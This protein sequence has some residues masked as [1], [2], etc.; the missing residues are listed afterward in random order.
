MTPPDQTL[1][2]AFVITG[3]EAHD[4]T[5]Y[6]ELMDLDETRPKALLADKGYDSDVIREEAWFH[7]TD[8]VIPTKS[9]R[10]ISDRSIRCFMPCAIASSV[11]S[12]TPGR[13]TLRQ[14]GR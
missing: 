7:G 14:N 11:S 1:P 8:P 2:L 6:G 5:I 4:A 3:G 9:N 10:K 12:T 13:H